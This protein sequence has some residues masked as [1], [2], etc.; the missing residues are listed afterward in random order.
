MHDF[1][2]LKL[3]LKTKF[4]NNELFTEIKLEYPNYPWTS[5]HKYS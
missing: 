4:E 5:A 3:S 2:G 1:S